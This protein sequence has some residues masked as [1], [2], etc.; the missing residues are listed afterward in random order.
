MIEIKPSHKGVF[1]EFAKAN[2][3]TVAEAAKHILA[4]KGEYSPEKVKQAVFANNVENNGLKKGGT[5][6]YENGT[7]PGG[8]KVPN[9]AALKAKAQNP[10]ATYA[11]K[12][13]Y[14]NAYNSTQAA[15][16]VPGTGLKFKSKA[17]A[18]TADTLPTINQTGI[19]I[20]SVEPKLRTA[21]GG[22]EIQ[23]VPQYTS[24]PQKT[25]DLNSG[26]GDA[27]GYGLPLLQGYLG[28]N[29]LQQAGARPVDQID[30]DYL[31][32]IA[33]A[34]KNT[35]LA[36]ANAKFGY[37]PQEQFSLDQQNQGALNNGLFAARNYSGGDAGNAFNQ[38]SSAIN[39]SF[40][41]G[42]Q[43]TIQGRQ[44]QM[45]KQDQ[46]YDRQGYLD[47]LIAG[48]QRYKRQLYGDKMAGWQQSQQAGSD[49]LGAGLQN[50]LGKSRYDEEKNAIDQRATKYNSNTPY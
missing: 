48:Q 36:N 21:S 35:D 5:V 1:T 23:Q 2:G 50:L 41:R 40:G 28:F 34:R 42:L 38:S 15:K 10:D 46:A 39:D 13:A 16:S 14:Y 31:A 45:A 33:T 6:G 20:N 30:P 43:A 18:I 32:S 27:L 25:P 7:P 44:L 49:L 8:V 22:P 29:K 26:L 17:P 37:T 11:D 3:M 47:N 19:P 12:K 9:L 24:A 4:N